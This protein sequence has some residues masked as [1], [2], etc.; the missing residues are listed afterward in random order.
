MEGSN[1]EA[2]AWQGLPDPGVDAGLR[3]AAGPGDEIDDRENLPRLFAFGLQ[4]VL[5]M[6]GETVAPPLVLGS[7]LHLSARQAIAHERRAKKIGQFGA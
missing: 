7:A 6:Y 3:V 1:E 5:V 2:G 4:H